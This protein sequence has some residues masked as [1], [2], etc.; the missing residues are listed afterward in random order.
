MQ[1]QWFTIE[2]NFN[3]TFASSFPCSSCTLK[4]GRCLCGNSICKDQIHFQEHERDE[5]YEIEANIPRTFYLGSPFISSR[6]PIFHKMTTILFELVVIWKKLVLTNFGWTPTFWQTPSFCLRLGKQPCCQDQNKLK[7]KVVGFQ[8]SRSIRINN[9]IGLLHQSSEMQIRLLYQSSQMQT[10][11][12]R[13][14][15]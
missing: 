5:K 6:E 8:S 2:D 9:Q 12:Q 11:Q 7:C 13:W 14:R 1:I 10:N 4:F 3:K 15:I